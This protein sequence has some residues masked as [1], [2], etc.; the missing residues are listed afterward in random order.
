MEAVDPPSSASSL[1]PWEV[2][3]EV[4]QEIEDQLL[5]LLTDA[6]CGSVEFLYAHDNLQRLYFDL[7]LL[8][9]LPIADNMEAGES[10]WP[11]DFDPWLE[12]AH[13]IW[14]FFIAADAQKK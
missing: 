12:L 8:S 5:P 6:H 13:G 7:N 4:R 10:V 11:K 3:E 14:E 9:T 1:I 2:P